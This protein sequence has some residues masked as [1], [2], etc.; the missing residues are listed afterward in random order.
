VGF[1]QLQMD[2]DGRPNLLRLTFS[3]AQS[4]EFTREPEP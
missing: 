2:K 1:V 4:Y 3:D